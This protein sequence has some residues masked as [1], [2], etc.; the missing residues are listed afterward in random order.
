MRTP[1][2][3]VAVLLAVVAAPVVAQAPPSATAD[4]RG[5]VN[6]PG[7]GRIRVTVWHND[8]AKHAIEPIAEGFADDAGRFAFDRVPWFVRQEWGR[9]SIVMVARRDGH[10]GLG[11]LRGDDAKVGAIAVTVAP[12]IALRGTVRGAD[13]KPLAGARVWPAQ[14]GANE[15]GMPRAWVTEPLL[16]WLAETAADGSFTLRDLPP[17]AP[18]K[19]RATHPDHATAWVDAVDPAQPVA[20]QLEAGGR[21]RGGVRTPDGKPAVRVLVAAAAN[22][23]GYAN[24]LTDDQGNFELTGLPPDTYKVWAEAPDLTV[25]AVTGIAVHGGQTS[26]AAIVQL[27]PGGFHRRPHPRR[28][29]RQAVRARPMDG[30][31]DVWAGARGR[32]RLRM[33]AGAARWH[34]P[35]PRSCRS[36]QDLP[37]R[38]RRRLQ[39]TDGARHGGGR[40]GDHRRVEADPRSAPALTLR[41]LTPPLRFRRVPRGAVRGLR[42]EP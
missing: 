35:H 15:K 34:V 38:R 17:L 8:M 1:T 33:H 25:I 42:P 22:G 30:R 7:T 6:G 3:A 5:T 9:H 37:A 13:G 4:L 32:R 31:R 20:A 41:R 39:R 2:F 29:D 16:P 21:I 24:A 11:T 28:G 14:F 27:T 26:D 12:T 23:I 36:Q 19:L 40:Q 18:F 10:A